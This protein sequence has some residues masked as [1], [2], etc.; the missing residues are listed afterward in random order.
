MKETC[1]AHS[2]LKSLCF[3]VNI[4]DVYNEFRDPISLIGLNINRNQLLVL[5][6]FENI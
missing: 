5:D 3:E 2:L 4:L 6:Y 1:I